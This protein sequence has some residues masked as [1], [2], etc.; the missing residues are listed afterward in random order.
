MRAAANPQRV[1]V[2]L[3]DSTEVTPKDVYLTRLMYRR[4]MGV[5]LW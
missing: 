3:T 4:K 5:T 1:V 2:C